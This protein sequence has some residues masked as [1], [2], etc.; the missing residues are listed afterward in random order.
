MGGAVG[1]GFVNLIRGAA[2]GCD[3]GW[4]AGGCCWGESEIVGRLDW[5]C[6][7]ASSPRA[8]KSDCEMLKDGPFDGVV[9]LFVSLF[10]LCCLEAEGG[11]GCIIRGG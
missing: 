2:C 11:G 4:D 7:G 10:I 3:C 9:V 8:G 6:G 1:E 5:D